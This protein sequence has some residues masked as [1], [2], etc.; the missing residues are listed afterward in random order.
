MKEWVEQIVEAQERMIEIK[1]KLSDRLEE[2]N[3]ELNSILV[4]NGDVMECP[5]IKACK[6][7]P[8]IKCEEFLAE[9]VCVEF[10]DACSA[11]V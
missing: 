11:M 9:N 10:V 3:D 6:E 8:R 4:K 7:L 1:H 5:K 2:K